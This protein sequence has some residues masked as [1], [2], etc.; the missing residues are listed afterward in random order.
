MLQRRIVRGVKGITEEL[1]RRFKFNKELTKRQ[2]DY[3]IS[4]NCLDG[5]E[6]IGPKTFI[7]HPD[8]LRLRPSEPQ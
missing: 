1:N 5:V 8:Q 7:G 6:K 4:K 3:L 2:V